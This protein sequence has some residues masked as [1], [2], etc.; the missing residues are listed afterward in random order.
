MSKVL[1]VKLVSTVFS[2]VMGFGQTGAGAADT[3]MKLG[4]SM[5]TL[6]T[7]FFTVLVDA[8]T[9]EAKAVGGASRRSPT[10]IVTPVSRSQTATVRYLLPPRRG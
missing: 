4:L 8:A 6:N 10:P 1:K 5:P 7:P 9:S 3:T 2:A